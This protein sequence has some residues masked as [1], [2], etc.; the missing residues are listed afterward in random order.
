VVL[1]VFSKKRGFSVQKT[2]PRLLSETILNAVIRPGTLCTACL[3]PGAAVCYD[4]AV[5]SKE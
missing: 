1:K 5:A 4:S 2:R 3:E